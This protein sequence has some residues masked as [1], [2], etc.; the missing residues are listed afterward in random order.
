MLAAFILK[1]RFGII[2]GAK[3][4][5]YMQTANASGRGLSLFEWSTAPTTVRSLRNNSY[6]YCTYLNINSSSI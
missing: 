2:N 4:I 5:R 6:A 1:F 3:P